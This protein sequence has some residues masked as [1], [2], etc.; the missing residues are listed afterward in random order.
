MFPE[1]RRERLKRRPADI[2]AG[3]NGAEWSAERNRLQ[4]FSSAFTLIELLVVISI[5]SL[6]V[7]ILLPS[8]SKAKEIAKK[9]VCS[10]NQKQ[11]GLAWAM[12]LQENADTFYDV[13]CWWIWGGKVGTLGAGHGPLPFNDPNV[14]RPLNY[15]VDDTVAVF[16]CPSD[17]GRPVT[18]WSETCTYDTVGNSYGYNCVGY[19]GAGGLAGI[20]T[21]QVKEPSKTILISDGGIF[22]NTPWHDKDDLWANLLFVDSHVDWKLITSSSSD[23]GWTFVP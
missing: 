22:G 6:L 3:P 8:I 16:S 13:A 2:P 4:R 1:E 10:S 5:I 12:Y 14:I 20:P 17:K 9:A 23:G 21:S 15:Y 11:L 7:S 19:A 18:L